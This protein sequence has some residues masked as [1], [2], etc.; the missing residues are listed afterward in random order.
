MPSW[1]RNLAIGT[2]CLIIGIVIGR[3][4]P[5]PF[6][7]HEPLEP[8]QTIPTPKPLLRYSFDNLQVY[9]PAPSQILLDS[10][11]FSE[12]D[13]TA[14]LAHFTTADKKMSLQ[15]M[16]PAMATPSA[17]F[18]VILML[19]G[20]V[21]T[22]IYETGIGTKNVAHYLAS[23]GFVTI[24]PD[25]LGYGDSDDP[26]LDTMAARLEKPA[27]LLD[28]IDSLNTLPFIDPDRLGMWGHSN[29]GQIALSL[30]EITNLPI[31]TVLWAPVTKP[32]PYSLL[33]Y[34]DEYDDG[35]KVLR[36]TIADFEVDYDVFHFSLDKYVDRLTGPIQLH[37]GGQ[38]DAVPQSWSDEFVHIVNQDRE[39]IEY[40]T[41]PSADH[42]LQPDW[43]TAVVRTYQFF[44]DT[45]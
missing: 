35:G 27:Q 19:R 10:V 32:F 15:I 28:L 5:N 38:D 24:A 21:D 31:P 11:M 18:P 37:Q 12:T 3:F 16:V 6:T 2:I 30:L 20:F 44:T 29:G 43:G 13:L 41:Y 7:P 25:F 4:L 1:I 36:Q 23:R 33:Y 17:G 40:F 45:I 9:Q 8:L 39:K 42:N 14:H 26:P 22:S 34:T